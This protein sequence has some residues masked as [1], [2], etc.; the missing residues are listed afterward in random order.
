MR[1]RRYLVTVERLPDLDPEPE[2]LSVKEG[3]S[4]LAVCGCRHEC[5]HR[6]NPTLSRHRTCRLGGDT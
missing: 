4:G 1:K 6:K 3:A 5:F 2:V